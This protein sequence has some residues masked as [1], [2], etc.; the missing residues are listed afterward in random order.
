M[1]RI[2][3]DSTKSDA[4]QLGFCAYYAGEPSSLNPFLELNVYWRNEWYDGWNHAWLE[5]LLTSN[6]PL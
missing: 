6:S 2:T 4:Y 5:G 3:F 1:S